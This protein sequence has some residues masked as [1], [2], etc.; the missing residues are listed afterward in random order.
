M[1]LIDLGLE[2]RPSSGCREGEVRTAL[3]ST[4]SGGL[5]AWFQRST[6]RSDNE[7][8]MSASVQLV[9]RRELS[10]EQLKA[11]KAWLTQAMLATFA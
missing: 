6:R 9:N 10:D 11:V 7:C 5:V 8:I 2:E 4:A 1:N 3:Y